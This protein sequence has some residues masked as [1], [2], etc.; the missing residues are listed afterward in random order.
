MGVTEQTSNGT[1]NKPT[2]SPFTQAV[3]DIWPKRWTECSCC[4][5]NVMKILKYTNVNRNVSEFMD[6]PDQA[7]MAIPTSQLSAKSHKHFLRYDTKGGQN[8]AAAMGM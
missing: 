8:A 4:H 2:F 7:L 6:V 3:P 1:S 5:G